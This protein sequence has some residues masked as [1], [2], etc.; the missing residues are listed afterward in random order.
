MHNTNLQS[1]THNEGQADQTTWPI[2]RLLCRAL[3]IMLINLS[4]C[5]EAN[6]SR[7]NVVAHSCNNNHHG[8]RVGPNRRYLLQSAT[9]CI[10]KA[11]PLK[12]EFPQNWTIG[13]V[14]VTPG[15]AIMAHQC[16]SRSACSLMPK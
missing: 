7:V 14:I 4:N 1:F 10:I 13:H 5:S 16:F 9:C 2:N 3:M 6:T 12:C 8:G 15:W 11:D